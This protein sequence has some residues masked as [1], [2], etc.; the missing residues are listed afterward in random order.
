MSLLWPAK[1]LMNPN[2]HLL[3]YKRIRICL[4]KLSI[5]NPLALPQSKGRLVTPLGTIKL[6][7]S[8]LGGMFLFLTANHNLAARQ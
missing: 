8:P 2:W 6:G 7:D 4:T 5:H 3:P 1:L